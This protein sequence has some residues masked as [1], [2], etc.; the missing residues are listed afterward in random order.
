MSDDDHPYAARD[1]RNPGG[2]RR[3]CSTGSAARWPRPGA[4]FAQLD[5]RFVD[6]VARGSSDHAAAFLK[7]AVELTAGVPVASLGPS[8]ASIYGARLKL[9]RLGQ[10]RHLAVGQEPGHRR[11]GAKPRAAAAR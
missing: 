10:P 9:A 7:Y 11:D 3:A 6:T 4:A 5:P 1:R 8:I 2:R